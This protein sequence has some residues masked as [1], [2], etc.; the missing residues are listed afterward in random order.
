MWAN[1][2]TSIKWTKFDTWA[3]DNLWMTLAMQSIK[4]FIGN[5][6]P[7]HHRRVQSITYNLY[8]CLCVCLCA[9]SIIV[10]R[11]GSHLPLGI[12]IFVSN[13]MRQ[14]DSSDWLWL[15]ATNWMAASQSMWSTEP[16]VLW[17]WSIRSF[18]SMITTSVIYVWLYGSSIDCCVNLNLVKTVKHRSTKQTF[19][20]RSFSLTYF[21]L[22][23]WYLTNLIV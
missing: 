9:S 10:N 20:D 23:H 1:Q 16:I 4:P 14:V 21:P 18:L 17:D 6:A 12:N 5:V 7:C 11:F 2:A 8:I 15:T 13:N 19:D 22:R 3:C